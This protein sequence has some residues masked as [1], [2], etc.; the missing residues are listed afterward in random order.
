MCN[1]TLL[2]KRPC[3]LLAHDVP[4]VVPSWAD[5]ALRYHKRNIAFS[6]V[7][8]A[9]LRFSSTPGTGGIEQIQRK[10]DPTN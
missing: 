2:P 10:D 8:L 9:R 6:V 3:T 1:K 7:I 5:D 4:V